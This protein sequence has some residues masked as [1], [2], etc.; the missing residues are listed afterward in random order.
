MKF[1]RVVTGLRDDGRSTVIFDSDSPNILEIPVWPGLAMATLW[2]TAETPAG[3]SGEEDRA[4]VPVGHDPPPLGSIFR[5]YQFPPDSAR[6]PNCGSLLGLQG[7]T[8]EDWANIHPMMHA[9]NSVDYLVILSGEMTMIME[10][11]SEVILRSGDCIVQRGTKHAWSNRASVPVVLIAVLID[12][13]A[14]S[15]DGGKQD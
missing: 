13:G 15:R 2:T 7:A 3:N 1:R 11:R 12:G 8:E 6:P 9:T 10:D 4:L 5:I 14:P